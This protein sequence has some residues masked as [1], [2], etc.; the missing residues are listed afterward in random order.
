MDD[1]SFVLD[2]IR[3]EWMLERIDEILRIRG[4]QDGLRSR[5][6]VVVFAVNEFWRKVLA[7][8]SAELGRECV[9]H[10]NLR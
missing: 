4:A 1:G 7:S 2:R 5:Q 8:R 6:D 9:W 10:R 3:Q